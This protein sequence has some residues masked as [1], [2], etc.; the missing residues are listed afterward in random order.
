M[1]ISELLKKDNIITNPQVTSK[2]QALEELAKYSANV[3]GIKYR[4]IFDQLLQREKLGT[5]G[6]GNGV[7]IPHCRIPQLDQIYGLF[8]KVNEPI[9]FD[10]IDEQ[11]VDLIFLLLAPESHGADHL[12]TLSKITRVLR[13]PRLCQKL[14][15]CQ[16]SDAIL[17]LLSDATCGHHAA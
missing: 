6:I 5:T 3:T 17:A 16:T 2:K 14:R 7:A 11:P 15:G 1:E 13:D 8:L 4:D 9:D 10:A 12:R